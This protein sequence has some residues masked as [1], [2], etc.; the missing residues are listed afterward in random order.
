MRRLSEPA[1]RELIAGAPSDPALVSVLRTAESVPPGTGD[2]ARQDA[3]P[4]ASPDYVLYWMQ[5][6]QR[7]ADNPALDLAL[8]CANTLELP[9][10]V[11]FVIVPA[12]GDAYPGAGPQHYEWMMAGV[13]EC[14]KDLWE[15]G[16]GF[17][18][19]RGKPEEL[20]LSYAK[21]AAL[22]VMDE[23]KLREELRWR[24]Y[25]VES[26]FCPPALAVETEAI[27][28]PCLVADHLL[29]SATACRARLLRS[30]RASLRYQEATR[31][32]ATREKSEAVHIM[33]S[34]SL[35]ARG[36]FAAGQTGSYPSTGV[37]QHF[38][39][40]P[41]QS[42]A[43]RRFEEF[44]DTGK[45]GA[46]GLARYSRLRN[47]PCAEAQSDMSPYLHF[48]N[49]ASRRLALMCLERSEDEASPYLEQLIV[50]RELA[51]NFVLQCKGYDDFEF[52]APDW[53]K[54]SLREGSSRT[55]IYPPSRL[56]KAETD[57]PYW[58][59]AQTELLVTGKMHGY[60]R[61]YWGKQ[62][63]S[64]FADPAR[65]FRVALD[66]NN[67]YSLDGRDP[68]GYAGVA[69]CFGRHDRPWPNHRL[70]GMVRAMTH[71]GLSRKFD[72][73]SYVAKMQA[74]RPEGGFLDLS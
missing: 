50:R 68:N 54:T 46:G 49:V 35:P 29:W 20:V 15:R 70:F 22:L 19:V 55:D 7:T 43:L 26:P 53:A 3:R 51:F 52:A 4:K 65:A 64:W 28:P 23:G 67:R 38:H 16:I 72:I 42:A 47:D 56:E 62:I 73:D 27:I 8:H 61:M 57:D 9:L 37:M 71:E 69:W 2:L 33:T 40:A 25:V 63:L 18:A 5:K 12:P 30:L 32:D 14:E 41:G 13:R 44:L 24:R 60:M 36:G 6:A 1:I 45:D 48:G 74:L 31:R 10:L 34:G 59:A 11:L 66:L 21:G 17:L 58:N 39:L